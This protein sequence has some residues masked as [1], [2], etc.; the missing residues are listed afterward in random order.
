MSRDDVIEILKIVNESQIT[1]L[2]LETG[3]L[4]LVLKKEGAL[5]SAGEAE[6]V[7]GKPAPF[8]AI[9]KDAAVGGVKAAESPAACPPENVRR[10]EPVSREDENLIPIRAPML[11]V[12]Y[13]ASKPG[14]PPFVEVGQSVTKDD[15]VCI[16]E[17][18][19]L[20]N[21]IRS[22]VQGRVVDI[23]AKDVTLV[24]YN[25]V[26]FWVEKEERKEEAQEAP[27]S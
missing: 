3:D 6:G 25:Q 17:V 5:G 22:G 12:F 1:E 2:Q 14:A 16:I 23:C 18:M 7:A 27:V 8:T 15:V 21:M 11:G 9:E 24:E 20:F 4:K 13:R 26:L 10:P 19:K